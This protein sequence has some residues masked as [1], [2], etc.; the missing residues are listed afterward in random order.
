V[1][2]RGETEKMRELTR[3]SGTRDRSDLESQSS[4]I[5]GAV[6]VWRVEKYNMR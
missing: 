2:P 5:W 4:T 6:V 1:G 3:R